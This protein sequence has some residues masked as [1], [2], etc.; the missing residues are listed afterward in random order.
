[1]EHDPED[2]CGFAGCRWGDLSATS[3]DEASWAGNLSGYDVEEGCT[4]SRLATF[5]AGDS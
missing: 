1:V 3:T 4:Y 5:A 2:G